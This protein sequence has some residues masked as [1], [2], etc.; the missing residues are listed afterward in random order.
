[1]LPCRAANHRRPQDIA[2]FVDCG[3]ADVMLDTAKKAG[4]GSR[5]LMWTPESAIF[6]EAAHQNDILCGLAGSLALSDISARGYLPADYL[7]FRG[8]P[9]DGLKREGSTSFIAASAIQAMR[10]L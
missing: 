5:D 10:Y 8:A 4:G 3:V 9:C 2:T 7:G 1:M 6:V